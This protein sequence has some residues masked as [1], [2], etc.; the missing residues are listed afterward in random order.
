M[1]VSVKKGFW[2]FDWEISITKT[3]LEVKYNDDNE[4]R[5]SAR[6]NREKFYSNYS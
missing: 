4:W 3:T 1:F 2:N 5:R 6:R